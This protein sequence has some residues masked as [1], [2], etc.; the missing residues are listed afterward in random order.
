MKHELPTSEL[1]R[2]ITLNVNDAPLRLR[3]LDEKGP[4]ALAVEVDDATD[5]E[6]ILEAT[7]AALRQHF[8]FADP[9]WGEEKLNERFCIDFGEHKTEVFVFGEGIDEET[10]SGIVKTLERM[11]NALVDKA[12][13]T[14]ESVQILPH[15]KTNLKNGELIRGMEF[16]NQRRFELYPKG[17]KPSMYRS[18]ELRCSELEGTIAHETTH[19][20]LEEI[21][22]AS[23]ETG[24]FGWETDESLKIELPGGSQT[25]TYN[26][27]P[28]ECP[29]SYGALKPD[30]DRADSVAAFLFD[31]KKL[32]QTRRDVL[33]RVLTNAGSSNHAIIKPVDPTLPELPSVPNVTV[34]ERKK[35]LFG[36]TAVRPG[37][38]SGIISLSDLRKARGIPEPK[39]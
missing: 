3:L 16:P 2:E 28:Q 32:H 4:G 12:L 25:N 24:D 11:Y 23:W 18:G 29:T 1:S 35:N 13:W 34:S 10:R 8:W 31:P 5:T 14:L 9:S 22:R 6:Q 17:L 7:T 19:V 30:D 36:L 21:L 33:E 39:F 38:K 37:K 15:E 27:R 20:L 26:K